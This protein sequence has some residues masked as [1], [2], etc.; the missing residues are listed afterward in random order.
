E[1]RP[2][3]ER[4]LVGDQHLADQVGAGDH[5]HPLW[6]QP[7]VDDVAVALRESRQRPDRVVVQADHDAQGAARAGARREREGRGQGSYSHD[8]RQ[9]FQPLSTFNDMYT[10]TPPWDIGRPQ[11]A[12]QRLAD[13]GALR[14]RVLDAGCGTGEHT[15]MAAALALDALG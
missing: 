10:G 7:E 12:F 6:S 13:E 3:L 15:L 11:P 14:G 5:V 2:L 8:R 4:L 9:G 1:P